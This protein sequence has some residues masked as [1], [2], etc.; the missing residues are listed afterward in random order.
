LLAKQTITFIKEQTLNAL[1]MSIKNYRI[2]R[3][4][5]SGGLGQVFK[6]ID[7]RS[8][9]TVAIKVLHKKYQQNSRFLGI[10]HRE[11]MI[12]S[13]FKHKHIVEYIGGNFDPP[14]CYI[15]SEFID[16]WSLYKLHR[17]CGRFPPL[18]ALSIILHVLQGIDYLHL[19]DTIHSDLSSPNVL[20][21]KSGRALVTDFGLACQEE[22]ENYQHY[23]IGTPGYYSPEHVSDAAIVPQSDI[24]CTGLLIYEMIT[25]NKAV[26]A[27]KDRNEILSGM[28]HIKFDSLPI[29]DSKMN[30]AVQSILKHSLHV[31]PNRRTRSTED[32]MMQV[33]QLLLKYNIRYARY[34]IRQFLRDR[35]LTNRE[36]EPRQV[37]NIYQ[38]YF[39][40]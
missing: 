10:F 13:R 20:I 35:G 16:G 36:V 11:L 3:E 31:N 21:E 22:V 23:M 26:V 18:V 33:S 29:T 25:G 8:G 32:M 17:D 15:I 5:G 4:I 14:E 37:Q 1:V 34:A 30:R 28:N 9:R 12:M 40:G 38:G 19:H 7:E 6:A 27:S 39:R 24:Y 2:I